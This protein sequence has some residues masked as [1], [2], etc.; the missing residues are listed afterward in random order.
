LF[1]KRW[2]PLACVLL[3]TTLSLVPLDIKSRLG[4]KGFFHAIDHLAA[5]SVT[6]LILCWDSR[7]IVSIVR[8]CVLVFA[9]GCTLELLQFFIYHNPFEWDD[10]LLDLVGVLFGVSIKGLRI[11]LQTRRAG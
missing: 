3:V 6:T 7:R 1:R 4:T 10:V 5:F 2:L 9:F 8:I 11:Y